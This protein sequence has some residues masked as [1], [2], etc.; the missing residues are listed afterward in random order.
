MILG[1]IMMTRLFNKKTNLTDDEYTAWIKRIPVYIFALLWYFIITPYLL[2]HLIIPLFRNNIDT[3]DYDNSALNVL[4][5]TLNDD[6]SIGIIPEE[7]YLNLFS[8]K[9]TIITPGQE[10]DEEKVYLYYLGTYSDEYAIFMSA[11]SPYLE[12]IYRNDGLNV[13]LLDKIFEG[14]TSKWSTTNKKLNVFYSS[15]L[16]NLDKSSVKTFQS[17]IC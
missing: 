7:Y 12:N 2:S 8:E 3:I 13:E 9:E 11:S 17:L 1:D 4:N 16:L 14:K 10:M 15:H 5:Y 6:S